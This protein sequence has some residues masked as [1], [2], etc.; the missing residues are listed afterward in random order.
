MP[1]KGE[2]NIFLAAFATLIGLLVPISLLYLI[3]RYSLAL[4]VF[5]VFVGCC[6]SLINMMMKK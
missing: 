5:L 1:P 3:I 4:F 6:L 2:A